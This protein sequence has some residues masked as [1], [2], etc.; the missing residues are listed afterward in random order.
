MHIPFL[1]P[2]LMPFHGETHTFWLE[3][4]KWFEIIPLLEALLASQEICEKI[5]LLQGRFDPFSP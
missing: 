3:D 5:E 2:K 4:M 1:P